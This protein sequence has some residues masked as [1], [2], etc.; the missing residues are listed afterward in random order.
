MQFNVYDIFYSLNS[1]HH[2]SAAIAA[3][4]KVMILLEEY[5]GAKVVSCVSVNPEQLK[6][7]II[8]VKNG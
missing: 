3:M 1:H 6:I 4:F 5:K 2:V 7:I 8:S